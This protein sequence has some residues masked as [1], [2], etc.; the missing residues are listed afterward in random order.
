MNNVILSLKLFVTPFL[1]IAILSLIDYDLA[2]YPLAFSLV[3]S[4]SNYQ[5]FKYPLALGILL[6]V[7]FAYLALLGGWLT[8]G[9]LYKVIHFL[10]IPNDVHI[11]DWFYTDVAFCMAVFLVAPILTYTFYKYL[12]KNAR[13]R[14][15]TI[16]FAST[17]WILFILSLFNN[18]LEREFFNMFNI[19]QLIIIFG[20][21]LMINQDEILNTINGKKASSQQRL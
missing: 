19:W 13:S 8:H 1:S 3:L 11:G 15:S 6:S 16:I 12:F 17:I 2:F 21:Q 7:L 9:I 5:K 18:N 20:M 10:N 14:L 4:I